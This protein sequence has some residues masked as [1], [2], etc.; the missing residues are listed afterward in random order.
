WLVGYLAKHGLAV[1]GWYRIALATVLAGLWLGGIVQF[2]PDQPA[3][4]TSP[5]ALASTPLD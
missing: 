3:D 5:V 4:E 2:G 1:F